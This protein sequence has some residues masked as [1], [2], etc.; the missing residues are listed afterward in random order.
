MKIEAL[1]KDVEAEMKGIPAG[2]D[3]TGLQYDSRKVGKGDLFVAVKGYETD[4]HRYL[5]AAKEKGAVLAVVEEINKTIDV[6]QVRVKDSRA[7]M[8]LLARNFHARKLA[9]FKMVGVTGTNGKTTT[10]FLI[11]QMLEKAGIS[12]GLIGTIRYIIG[13]KRVNSWNTT[14]EAIDLYDMMVQMADAGNKACVLEVSSHALALKRVYGFSFDAAVF[15]NLSRDHLDFHQDMETYFAEK[16][17]LF[18]QLSGLGKA[19]VN[20]DDMYGKTLADELGAKAVTFGKAED[21]DI[22]ALNWEITAEGTSINVMTGDE[23]MLIKSPLIGEFNVYNILGAVGAGLQLGLEPA[24]IEQG[25]ASLD[26]VPGRLQK[27]TLN[28]GAIA[29]IDYA[30]TPDAL[31]KALRTLRGLTAGKLIVVFGCGG[32]RDRGKRPEMGKIA[33]DCADMIIVT[34]D[35][36]RTE[37]PQRIIDDILAGTRPSPNLRV[38]NDRRRALAD[39]LEQTSPGDVLLVAGKGH[40]TYQ[41]LGTVKHP[42]DEAAIIREL[43]NA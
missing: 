36:P 6:P 41:V 42:F 33:Q 43:D 38:V 35:N 21:C 17:R 24:Q 37:D 31:E 22:R 10:V 19:I 7:A 30:H 25:L 32:D 4:G 29:V 23:E 28:N 34:D 15:T 14:P 39:A 3:V 26:A 8:A 12:C 1:F 5:P 18:E 20:A 13:K 11:R 16:K 40:E 9:G 27:I 2:I